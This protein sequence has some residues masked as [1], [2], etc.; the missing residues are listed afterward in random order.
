MSFVIEFIKEVTANPEFKAYVAQIVKE[1]YPEVSYEDIILEEEAKLILGV[2]GKPVSPRQMAR[3]RAM[4]DGKA[5]KYIP[6]SPIRY[7]RKHV[8]EFRDQNLT[9]QRNV[10]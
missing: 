3:Y 6:G 5:L 2:K 7:V 1:V 8:I 10:A 4:K 9:F